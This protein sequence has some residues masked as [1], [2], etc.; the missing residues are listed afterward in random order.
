MSETGRAMTTSNST[1]IILRRMR[2]DEQALAAT[3]AVTSEQLQFVVP[4]QL[5][6]KTTALERDN[7]IIETDAGIVGFFQI[8]TRVPEYVRQPLLELCQ[9]VI[10]QNHQ[11]RGIGRR[12]IQSLPEL[13]RRE[14]PDATGVVLT[15]NCRNKMAHRVYVA[16]GFRDTGEIYTG[17][18]SGPQH[19]MTMCWSDQT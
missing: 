13:L 4:M 14:Y 15:V 8:D 1:S 10:D 19:I 3:L 5:T 7:F 6:M 9:V 16:G 11:G 12:F 2:E 18:P 17:G